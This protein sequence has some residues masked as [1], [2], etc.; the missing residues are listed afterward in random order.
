MVPFLFADK[1]TC[2]D[3]LDGQRT[4][5]ADS[6]AVSEKKGSFLLE[7]PEVALRPADYGLYF[8]LGSKAGNCVRQFE[9]S[10]RVIPDVDHLVRSAGPA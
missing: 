10:E 6:P 4:P 1:D 3:H 5:L 9:F 8:W 7:F 2:R